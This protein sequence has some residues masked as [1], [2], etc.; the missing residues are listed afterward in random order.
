M[1]ANDNGRHERWMLAGDCLVLHRSPHWLAFGVWVA[2][3]VVLLFIFEYLALVA[4]AC[5][6]SYALRECWTFSMHTPRLV[7][8]TLAHNLP[9]FHRHVVLGQ[10]TGITV[11]ESITSEPN[12]KW[13]MYELVIWH[14]EGAPVSVP[15]SSRI[16]CEAF[17]YELRQLYRLADVSL[18]PPQQTS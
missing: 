7:R 17:G 3:A 14:S 16:P 11:R 13:R 12:T 10:P 18:S 4:F 1:F 9:L 6:I 8:S 2:V 5:S 15:F